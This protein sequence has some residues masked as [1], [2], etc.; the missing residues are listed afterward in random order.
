MGAVY[1]AV[2]LRLR[3]TVAIKET[4]V[5]G[6]TYAKAFEREACLLASLRHAA[7]PVVVDYFLEGEGQFLVMQFIPGK[8]L[9]RLLSDNGGPFPVS[10]VARWADQLLAAVGYLHS[11]TPPVLHR[12]IKPQNLKMTDRGEIVLLDFGLARGSL[13]TVSRSALSTGS[14]V[15]GYT[16]HYA[17]LEQIEG[18]G[19]DAR[20]DLYGVGATMYHLLTGVK[21]ADALARAMALVSGRKDPLVSANKVLPTVSPALAEVLDWSLAQSAEDRPNSANELRSAFK[22][23][24]RGVVADNTSFQSQTV[25]PPRPSTSPL[26]PAAAAFTRP[27]TPRESAPLTATPQTRQNP[28]TAVECTVIRLDERGT[29]VERKTAAVDVFTETVNG[30]VFE[31]S[32]I[33]AGRLTSEKSGKDVEMEAFF[34]GRTP[35]T[36]AQ[37]RAV[38]ALPKVEAVIEANPSF[39]KGDDR[40][41]EQVSWHDAREFCARLSSKT[42][43]RYRLPSE[44]EWEFACRAG[45]HDDFHFG[46]VVTTDFANFDGTYVY[47][48]AP[49]GIFRKQTTPVGQFKVA[50]G[51]GLF[52][53]HGNVWEWCEDAY[54]HR[55]VS[56]DLTRVAGVIVQPRVIRGGSWY[57]RADACRSWSVAGLPPDSRNGRSG[58][59][60]ALIL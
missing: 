14:S 51:F 6:E 3:S 12:D 43:R 58:F 1:K 16:M 18:S 53:M 10:V 13:A 21:P 24:L 42:G 48:S 55:A 41:V 57:G 49:R 23:A 60:I 2:D 11:I 33:P 8:D 25:L 36:Q 54:E 59:R 56:G 47:G 5:E 28:L 44:N 35:V 34:I 29:V 27:A 22:T 39:F 45:G 46:P 7:L 52:D 31:L 38:A 26:K 15:L 4:L 40:P 50:N 20:S 9:G 32:S 17:P 37:W 30:V 19:T